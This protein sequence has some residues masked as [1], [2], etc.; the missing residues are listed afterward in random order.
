MKKKKLRI[1]LG[2]AIILAMVSVFYPT[3][4][5]YKNSSETKFS[6]YYIRK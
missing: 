1:L 4:A 3:Y 6:T 5:Q 2:I